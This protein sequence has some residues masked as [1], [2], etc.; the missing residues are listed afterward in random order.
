[1]TTPLIEALDIGLSHPFGVN[2][3][4]PA[5]TI[6]PAVPATRAVQTSFHHPGARLSLAGLTTIL[7]TQLAQRDPRANES[8][9]GP[10]GWLLAADIA[11]IILNSI[12]GLPDFPRDIIRFGG[13][14]RGACALLLERLPAALLDSVAACGPTTRTLAA[15]GAR[16]REVRPTGYVVGPDRPDE[17]LM[18]DGVLV[19]IDDDDASP[20]GAPFVASLLARHDWEAV[21]ASEPAQRIV[22]DPEAPATFAALRCLHTTIALRP[23]WTVAE[24]RYG[25]TGASHHPDE[26]TFVTGENG[27]GVAVRFWWR[28]GGDVGGCPSDGGQPTAMTSQELARRL[29]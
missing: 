5:S 23:L 20:L 11:P 19:S 29:G 10:A 13:L 16:H 22:E 28:W 6:N 27:D 17:R 15:A 1:M 24:R 7:T 4:H 8:R 21:D 12:S 25:L 18:L 26:I 2:P 14:T 3:V 9:F